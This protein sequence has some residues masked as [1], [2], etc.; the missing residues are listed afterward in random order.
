MKKTQPKIFL[1][2]LAIL[3]GLALYY[4]HYEDRNKLIDAR[5][6]KLENTHNRAV[7][8]FTDAIDKMAGLVAGMKGYIHAYDSIPS[9]EQF[10]SFVKKQLSDIKSA[11]SIAVSYIDSSHVFRQAFTRNKID[12]EG[13]IGKNVSSLRTP[14]KT[15][16]LNKLMQQDELKMF[17]PINLK[18][19]WLGVPIHFRVFKNNKVYGYVAPVLSFESIMS[20][21]YH[22]EN[23]RDFIFKFYTEDGIAFDRTRIY[24]DTKVYNTDKDVEYYKNFDVKKNNFINTTKDYYGFKITIGTAYKKE[25]SVI[26]DYSLVLL[27]GYLFFLGTLVIIFFQ[28]KKLTITSEE[29]KQLNSTKDRFFSILGHDLKQPLNSV[30]GLLYLVKDKTL[31]SKDLDDILNQLDNSLESTIIL[32]DNLL[33]WGSS[34]ANEVVFNPKALFIKD[35]IHRSVELHKEAIES[36]K[37]KLD[38]DIQVEKIFA[39]QDM[40]DTILRNVLSNAIKFTFDRGTISVLVTETNDYTQIK[41][42]DNGIG[43]SSELVAKILE[44]SSLSSTEGTKGEKGTG[45]GLVLSNDFVLKHKG[46]IHVE[47]EIKQGTTFTLRFPK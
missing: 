23:P 4:L 33:R 15:K 28:W 13:L 6:K 37:I 40:L 38:I 46:T 19:G 45:L 21:I 17:P 16:M 1:V 41:I 27:F 2:I 36:K 25:Y 5:N 26:N 35:T 31:Q 34:Q 20:S 22:E 43:M 24:D 7:D 30:K 9:Q 32:L 42:S 29:L 3:G 44:F 14:R 39:D 12:P 10:H 47:S 11:D 8:H 18:E